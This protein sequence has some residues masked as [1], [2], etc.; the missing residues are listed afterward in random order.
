MDQRFYDMLEANPVIAAV[1]DEE[2]LEKC[3][4]LEEV[5]V[6]FMM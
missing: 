6:V 3:C 2:G 4:G 5:K 1:K